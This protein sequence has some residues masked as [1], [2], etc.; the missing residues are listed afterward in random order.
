MVGFGWG[1]LASSAANPPAAKQRGIPAYSPQPRRGLLLPARVPWE[2]AIASV[3]R[4]VVGSCGLSQRPGDEAGRVDPLAADVE[5][6]RGD[7][8]LQGPM[9]R[10]CAVSCEARCLDATEY[11][12]IA[13]GPVRSKASPVARL[14]RRAADIKYR[15]LT[16]GGQQ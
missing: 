9:G 8:G 5:I 11:Q 12:R 10:M 15:I 1:K 3:R 2:S 6:A 14:S 7:C 13:E 16:G 4:F